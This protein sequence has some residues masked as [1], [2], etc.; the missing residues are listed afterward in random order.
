MKGK[1]LRQMKKQAAPWIF[2][3]PALLVYIFV[4]IVPVLYSLTYS[5]YDYNGIGEM[6]FN[7]LANYRDMFSDGTFRTAVRNNLLLMAGS[8]A[9]QMGLGLGLA[10]LQQYPEI[11]QRAAGSLFRPLYHILRGDLPDFFPDVFH[12][13]RRGDPRA[14]ASFRTGTCGVSV[15][16]PLGADCGD[17]SGCV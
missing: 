7:G 4:V 11:R 3:G 1:R 17:F 15:R 2:S 6:T 13:P 10:I 9:I 8:T 5:F 12:R 14:D 16:F